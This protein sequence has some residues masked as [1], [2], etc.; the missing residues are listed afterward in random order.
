[1]VKKSTNSKGGSSY[2]LIVLSETFYLFTVY[3]AAARRQNIKAIVQ[4]NLEQVASVEVV[5]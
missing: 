2:A 4:A 5:C 3:A 1:M